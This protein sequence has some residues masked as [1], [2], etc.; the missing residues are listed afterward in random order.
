MSQS[1]ASNRPRPDPMTRVIVRDAV[2][3]LRQCRPDLD[4]SQVASLIAEAA[5]DVVAAYDGD[6]VAFEEGYRLAELY[7]GRRREA[8]G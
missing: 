4:G 6:A 5:L 1:P 3:A 8:V 7:T 2:T